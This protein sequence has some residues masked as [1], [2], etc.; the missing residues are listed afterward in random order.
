MQAMS[1]DMK[2]QKEERVLCYHGPMLYE[3][4]VLK[5]EV[6]TEDDNPDEAG[7]HYFVHY[8][9]WKTTCVGPLDLRLDP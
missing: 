5:A 7:A 4:K 2:F 1:H 8:R 9:G 6:W 3:A